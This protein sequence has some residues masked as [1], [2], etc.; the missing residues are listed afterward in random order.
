MASSKNRKAAALALA[1]VGVAGL[2]IASAAQLNVGSAQLGAG[3]SVVASCQPGTAAADAI[4]VSFD[5]AY[6]SGA[7]AYNASAMTLSNINAACAG[8]NY[9]VNVNG[10]EL[11]GTISPITAPAKGSLTVNL[12][13][14]TSAVS[15]TDVAV[16][17]FS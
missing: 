2:S 9:K 14:N 1:V 17:I 12:G 15:I 8:Q 7:K 5:T 13:A 3:Q 6:A 16:V 11:T 4:K 10:Q